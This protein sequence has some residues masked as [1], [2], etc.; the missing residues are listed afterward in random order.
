MGDRA[1]V[2]PLRR[3]GRFGHR[4][5]CRS[6]AVGRLWLWTDTPWAST[7]PRGWPQRA[8]TATST[9]V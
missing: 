3:G 4:Q 7:V 9:D 1:T 5:L 6:A 8:S 2:S